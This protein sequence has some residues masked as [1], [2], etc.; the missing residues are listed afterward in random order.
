MTHVILTFD[1]SRGEIRTRNA[2]LRDREFDR[3]TYTTFLGSA[4]P[5]R[6]WFV[7]SVLFPDG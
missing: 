4:L 7:V 6:L 5:N 3:L 1:R 2:G